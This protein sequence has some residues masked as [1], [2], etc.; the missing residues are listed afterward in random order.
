MGAAAILYVD[1]SPTSVLGKETK[2]VASVARRQY[3]TE[4]VRYSSRMVAE[5]AE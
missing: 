5:L 1:T 3:R 4:M 2:L